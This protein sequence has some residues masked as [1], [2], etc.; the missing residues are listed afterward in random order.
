MHICHEIWSTLYELYIYMAVV[1]IKWKMVC[2]L[3]IS[4]NR[5]RIWLRDEIS[6]IMIT[7][8]C[9][10]KFGNIINIVN[11]VYACMGD[12][13]VSLNVYMLCMCWMKYE[14]KHL[15][16]HKCGLESNL[17]IVS[18]FTWINIW[19]RENKIVR[20]INYP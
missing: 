9:G 20:N 15:S 13:F 12:K 1:L 18:T 7:S 3:A 4:L 10:I 2:S 11:N 14:V 19:W 5:P 8:E 6:N 16:F 17:L